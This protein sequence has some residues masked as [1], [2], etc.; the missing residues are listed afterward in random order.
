MQLLEAS[1]DGTSV[2]PRVSGQTIIV[3]L[4][5]VLKKHGHV[6]VHT[7][8]RATLLNSVAGHDWLWAQKDGVASVYRSIPWLSAR[9]SFER[10]NIG[11]PFVTPVASRVRVTFTSAASVQFAT[12]GTRVASAEPGVT[13]E[14]HDVRDFNFTASRKYVSLTGKTLDGQTRLRVMTRWATSRQQ[15]GMLDVAQRAIAQYE[16]WVGQLPC[17][18]V[19]IAETAGGSAMESPCLIWIPR[20]AGANIDYLVAHELG[21]QWFY[22]VVGNDQAADPFLDEGM[23]DFL[24]RTFLHQLRASR[25]PEGPPGPVHLPV[26]RHLLLR[27]DLHPGQ[28]LPEAAQADHGPPAVLGHAPGVL[29]GP[30]L[31]GLEHVP[32]PGGVPRRGR[33]RGPAAVPGAFPEPLSALMARLRPWLP[34]PRAA[35]ALIGG[36]AGGPRRPRGPS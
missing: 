13:Y 10:N 16:A 21:H 5:Q 24:A 28:P 2:T 17:P 4:P 15:Q 8:Y 35:G 23:T 7:R 34:G 6:S 32:A 9:K 25:C 3:T 29:G 20:G 36:A 22:G 26:Q 33:R 31:H 18:T 14:A 11:D 30:P 27:N 12:T 1:V 19:T